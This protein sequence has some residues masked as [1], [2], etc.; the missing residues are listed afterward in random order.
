M[1]PLGLWREAWRNLLLHRSRSA[2]AILGI[3][4]GV[5]S[6]ICMTSISEVARRDVTSR[7]ERLGLRNV[8]V[9]SIKPQAVADEERRDTGASRIARY[10]VTR[11]DLEVLK[12]SLPQIETVLPIRILSQDLYAGLKKAEAAVAATTPDYPR[13][14]EHAISRGRFLTA[15]DESRCLPV[16]VLGYETARALFPLEDP[17]DRFVKIGSLPFRV[18]GILSLKGQTGTGSA[19]SN[20]DQTVFLPFSSS[21]ARFG[22]LQIRVGQGSQEATQIE[23]H[24]TV[25]R[26]ADR[27]LLA[28]VA[29]ATLNLMRKRH[30]AGDVEVSLPY[31]L[32][33]EHRRSE[34]IFLWVMGSIAAISLLVGGIGIMNIMLANVAERR[35][36][37][38]LRRALGATQGEV[39]RLFLGE[40]ILLCAVGGVLGL[41]AGIGL[42]R[43]VGALAGWTVAF[44]P[45]TFP[46]GLA[47]A[48]LAGLLFGTLPARRAARL[49]P[50]LAL[51]SE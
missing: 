41:G 8:I 39:L 15:M 27:A 24:R 50:V 6:V 49:D 16:C 1:R 17:L 48:M 20:P 13:V 10:G 26:V 9:D 35:P 28:P 34:R 31:A 7:I 23:V 29:Q 38:G 44:Q 42:A 5:A 18:V 46:L 12:A 37:I 45:L 33:E 19:L 3:I 14:M 25:L 11:A 32:L 47:V 21:F 51:R 4:F 43:A 40:S 2:L 36:E 30:Q 22:S